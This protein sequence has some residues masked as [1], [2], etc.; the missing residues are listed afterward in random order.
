VH[1][2]VLA[3]AH[4]SNR[5]VPIRPGP[6]N[7]AQPTPP[8]VIGLTASPAR[9]QRVPHAIGLLSIA[10]LALAAVG[11]AVPARA[12][13][14]VRGGSFGLTPTLTSGGRP[15]SYFNLT[16]PPGK[17]TR[18]TAIISN[19]GSRT[20]RL[21]ITIS[22]GVT[23]ANSGSAYQTAPGGC[24]GASC[25][26]TGLP[27]AVTL[28]PGERRALRF[29][30]AVPADAQSAQYLTGITAES[31]ARSSAVA[32]GSNG[33]ASAK[34]IIVKQVT[35]GVAITVGALTQMKTALAVAPVSAGWIGHTPRLLI[36]V[37]NPGQTFVKAKGTI[38]CRVHDR[39]HSYDV[40]MQTV[41]PGTN[42]VL[43]INAPGLSGESVP[44]KVR[45]REGT[46]PAALW[47]GT[48]TLPS[49]TQKKIIHTGNGAYTT[50]PDNTVPPWA[51]ALMVLGALILTALLVLLVLQRKHRQRTP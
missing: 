46:G 17:T 13:G 34:A 24:T 43:P 4:T 7:E 51:I 36:P 39:P 41:L 45:L 32:A 37:H 11:T 12:G 9:R 15:R 22:P 19:T 44:C 31:L 21:K 16:V 25:W 48:V 40:I 26:V 10:A 14:G 33:Q 1:A 30:V 20:Q 38:S 27:T 50:L 3:S 18:D 35:A 49:R 42:A 23:A 8:E 47:S 29:R 28:A 2:N 5:T 6:V